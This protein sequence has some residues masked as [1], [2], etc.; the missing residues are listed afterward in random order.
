MKRHFFILPILLLFIQSHA[1]CWA[2]DT[3]Q[4]VKVSSALRNVIVWD[5]AF[6]MPQ[7]DR[8]RKIRIYLPKDYYADIDKRYPVLYLQDGQ[9]LFDKQTS[10]AGEWE[11]DESLSRLEANGV[12]ACI[13]V[14][15]DNG[16]A[17]RM[18]EYSPYVNPTYGGGRGADYA[19][20]LSSTLKPAIDQN[21][22]TLSDRNS[23]FIG[24][25]SLGANISLY[26]CFR[27]PD[28]Y[29]GA[30]LFS[31]ALWFSDSLM[32]FVQTHLTANPIRVAQIVG[33]NESASMVPLAE[34]L[35]SILKAGNANE[36]NFLLKEIPDGEHSEWFWRREFP[37]AFQWLMQ[38][39]E[40][41]I[42]LPS[43]I[44]ESNTKV[45]PNPAS[46]F[47]EIKSTYVIDSIQL[48]NA[49]GKVIL[50]RPIG[51]TQA[52]IDLTQIPR[53]NYNLLLRSR[54][55][56]FSKRLTLN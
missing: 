51:S 28:I 21:F 10:F 17:L 46:Q 26:T 55:L 45:Y 3:K 30:L 2:Q 50:S 12:G 16:G 52:R 22:R 27:Y 5:T 32:D 14:G 49:K 40:E 11:V 53:G 6:F 56:F 19:A 31:P 20:F 15:I 54:E 44:L 36:D 13:V 37:D 41:Q 43:K 4:D 35:D 23:T 8:T 18:E 38:R 42:V 34:R 33:M 1:N 47:V 24:G 48:M 29:G 9:N 25:S 7:L 39:S